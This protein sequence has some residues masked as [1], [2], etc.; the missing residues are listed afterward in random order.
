MDS[1][2]TDRD[3]TKNITKLKTFVHDRLPTGSPLRDLILSEADELP[4]SELAVKISV[5]LKLLKR[6]GD[7]D[8]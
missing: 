8:S 3:K 1:H 6:L 7:P 5:Y 2:E 4:S